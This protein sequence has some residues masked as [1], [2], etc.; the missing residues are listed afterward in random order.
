MHAACLVACGA[1]TGGSSVLAAKR[2]MQIGRGVVEVV[3][4]GLHV[5]FGSLLS[6]KM[7]LHALLLRVLLV[8]ILDVVYG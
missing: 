8:A 2:L 5:S 7:K 3:G 6:K 4:T 1:R